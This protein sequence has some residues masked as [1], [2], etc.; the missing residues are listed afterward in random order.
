MFLLKPIT[1]CATVDTLF[2]LHSTMFLLILVPFYLIILTMLFFTFHYVSINTR[3]CASDL[4]WQQSLHSTMFLLIQKLE[5]HIFQHQKSLHSTMFLLIRE[6]APEE[7]SIRK[8]LHFTMFLLI[9]RC[10]SG[11]RDNLPDFTFHY[12]SINTWHSDHGN[13]GTVRLYIPLCFY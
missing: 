8:S 12:V 3:K 13:H 11:E 4:S 1:S 6:T 10:C 7:R 2:P 5:F 9:L